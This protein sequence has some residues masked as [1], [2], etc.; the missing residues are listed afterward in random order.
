MLFATLRMKK[1]RRGSKRKDKRR[2]MKGLKDMRKIRKMLKGPKERNLNLRKQL[3][4]EKI[5]GKMHLRK[6]D[7]LK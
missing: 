1:L 5:K 3:P 4:K 2:L 7:L 6:V